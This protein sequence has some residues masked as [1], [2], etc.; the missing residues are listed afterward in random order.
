MAIMNYITL[1]VITF[2]FLPVTWGADRENTGAYKFGV[3]PYLSAERMDDIYAPIS[4]K[5]TQ[6]LNRKVKFRTSSTFKIFLGKLKEEY[7]DFALIQPFWYPIAVDEKGYIS[8]LRMKEPFVSLIMVPDGSQIHKPDDL[9]GKIIATPPAFVPVVHMA[10]RALIKRGIV[11]GKDVTLIA[12]K[13]V[14]SCFQNVL[15]GKASACVAPPFASAI[16]EESMNVKLRTIVKSFSIPNLAFII[17]PRVP[18]QDRL[19][20]RQ[21]IMSWNA[22]EKGRKLLARMQTKGFVPIIDK[23]YD[24][25]RVFLKEIER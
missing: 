2:G 11:P 24:A 6:I 3:F 15:I 25:V 13:S 12:Y 1:L 22:S 17:H 7:Y 4:S 23:E 9:R 8:L 10:K 14:D 18:E 21:T 16:F 20:I 19:R 5:L